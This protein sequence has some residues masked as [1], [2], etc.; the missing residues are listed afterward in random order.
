MIKL[1]DIEKMYQDAH[2][3]ACYKFDCMFE[4]LDIVGRDLL[5]YYSSRASDTQLLSM[6]INELEKELQTMKIKRDEA[7]RHLYIMSETQEICPR[8]L[9]R[10]IDGEEH[11]IDFFYEDLQTHSFEYIV[12]DMKH[13]I[14]LATFTLDYLIN[15]LRQKK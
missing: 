3:G 5:V 14:D 6:A 11:N 9:R 13:S 15:K 8:S 12:H 1:I 4:Q 10:N 2:I 7:S